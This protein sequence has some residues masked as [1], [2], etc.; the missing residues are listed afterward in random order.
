SRGGE[1]VLRMGADAGSAGA[2]RRQRQLSSAVERRDPGAAGGAGP[3]EAQA[4]RLRLCEIRVI[5]GAQA[6][7]HP[8]DQ[9]CEER[10]VSGDAVLRSLRETPMQGID[11]RRGRPVPR[12]ST[13]RSV[14]FV[15]AWASLL[16][17]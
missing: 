12:L 10:Q 14:I 16:L 3:A 2:R 15:A 9:G 11:G 8:L 1:A 5:G 6:P 4:D 17:L 13:A 7:A